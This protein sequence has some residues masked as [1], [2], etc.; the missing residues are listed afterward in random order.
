MA[1]YRLDSNVFMEAKDGPYSFDIL[2]DFWVWLEQQAS[3][4]IICSSS[5]VYEELLAGNDDLAAWVRAWLSSRAWHGCP[6]ALRLFPEGP[7]RAQFLRLRWV[8]EPG[9]LSQRCQ[10]LARLG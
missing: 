8:L 2:P 5:T 4:G 1:Q 9:A 7:H 3:T 10:S 6:P